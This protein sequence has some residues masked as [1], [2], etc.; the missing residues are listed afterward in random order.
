VFQNDNVRIIHVHMQ[1][2]KEKIAGSV[3]KSQ[4]TRKND[5]VF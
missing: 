4:Q 5:G 1:F 2:G 3:K